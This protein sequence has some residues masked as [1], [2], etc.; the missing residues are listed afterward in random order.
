MPGNIKEVHTRR[1]IMDN[2]VTFSMAG[3]IFMITVWSAIIALTIF[4]FSRILKEKQEK[5]YR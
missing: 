3:I 4:C 5:D 2:E 1:L